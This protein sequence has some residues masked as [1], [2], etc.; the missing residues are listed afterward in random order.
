MAI[1]SGDTDK[2]SSDGSK[3]TYQLIVRKGC[4]KKS[5]FLENVGQT[6]TDQSPIFKKGAKN[7]Y[8]YQTNL[9]EDSSG[10]NGQ[11]YGILGTIEGSLVKITSGEV[12]QSVS[13]KPDNLKWQMEACH[14]DWRMCNSGGRFGPSVLNSGIW[15][16]LLVTL[17][18][19]KLL[20]PLE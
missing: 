12:F 15:P 10:G 1:I 17:S 5:D 7:E 20:Y 18:L 9:I 4:S 11:S 13:E 19:M 6:G 8:C 16:S 2:V 3:E 14:C